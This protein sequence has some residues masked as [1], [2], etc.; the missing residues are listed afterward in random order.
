MLITPSDLLTFAK[1]V[2]GCICVNPGMLMKASAAGSYASLTIDPLVSHAQD[3]NATA[4]GNRAGD[5]IRV[6]VINI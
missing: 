3:E 6:E 4:L 5:R 2:E 1:N